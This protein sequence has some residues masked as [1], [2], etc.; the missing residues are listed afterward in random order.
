MG[1]RFLPITVIFGTDHL[2]ERIRHLAR[3]S[4]HV[5]RF[6][7]SVQVVDFDQDF[8]RPTISRQLKAL[9]DMQLLAMRRAEPIQKAIV[10]LKPFGP[11]AE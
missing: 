2:Q 7:E 1:N 8:Q 11:V 3:A 5:E 10:D 9:D 6:V 4:R